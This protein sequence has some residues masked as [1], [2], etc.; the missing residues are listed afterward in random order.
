MQEE[1]I[2][3]ANLTL[4]C[5]DVHKRPCDCLAGVFVAKPWPKKRA[6]AHSAHNGTAEP[7]EPALVGAA[8]RGPELWCLAPCGCGI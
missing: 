7:M 6:V 1:G 2:A 3:A 8:K 4:V 5:L